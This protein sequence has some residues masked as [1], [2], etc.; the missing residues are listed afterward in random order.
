MPHVNGALTIG[1]NIGDLSGVTIVIKAYAF[2][3]Q[4]SG[5]RNRRKRRSNSRNFSE[6]VHIW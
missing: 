3:L 4:E 1:D 2:A 6:C 5:A